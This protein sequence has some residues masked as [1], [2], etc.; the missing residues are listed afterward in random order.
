MPVSISLGQSGPESNDNIGV[1]LH[2]LN[3]KLDHHYLCNL[4]LYPGNPFG[5]E[6][7]PSACNTVCIC[8][9]N[10]VIQENVQTDKPCM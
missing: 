7:Y 5:G 6:S 4:M 2:S 8:H 3:S 1:T 10:T 9:T